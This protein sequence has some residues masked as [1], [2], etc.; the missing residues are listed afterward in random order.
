MNAISFATSCPPLSIWR[1]NSSAGME[2]LGRPVYRKLGEVFG[3]G[4]EGGC[5]VY[6]GDA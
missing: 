2:S 1:S 3:L 5:A 6:L 4:L